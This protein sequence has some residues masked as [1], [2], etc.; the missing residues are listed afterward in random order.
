MLKSFSVQ[1]A[2][3]C[4]IITFYIIILTTTIVVVN[5]SIE[6]V[7]IEESSFDALKTLLCSVWLIVA[8]PRKL[9]LSSAL[10]FDLKYVCLLCHR[11]F[12][13][14]ENYSLVPFSGKSMFNSDSKQL[15]KQFPEI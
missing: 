1:I 6:N 3:F 12:L 10:E 5:C 11:I 4:P 13:S 2:S 15:N 14:I 7:G 9:V 8:D